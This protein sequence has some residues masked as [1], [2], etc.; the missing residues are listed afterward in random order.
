MGLLKIGSPI[1]PVGH[2]LT[3]LTMSPNALV[4]AVKDNVVPG[5]CTV[6]CKRRRFDCRSSCVVCIFLDGICDVDFVFGVDR[7]DVMFGMLLLLSC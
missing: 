7:N 3:R 5:I 1:A 2:A 4:G 6:R